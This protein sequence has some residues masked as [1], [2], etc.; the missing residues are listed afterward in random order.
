MSRGSR[1]RCSL[2]AHT[3]FLIPADLFGNQEPVRSNVCQQM[4]LQVLDPLLSDRP[5]IIIDNERF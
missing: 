1:R 2:P 3:A 5:G 4:H